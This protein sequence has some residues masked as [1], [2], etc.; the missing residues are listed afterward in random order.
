MLKVT[1][2]LLE[3]LIKNTFKQENSQGKL[4]EVMTC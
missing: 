4:V 3:M 2:K 1:I